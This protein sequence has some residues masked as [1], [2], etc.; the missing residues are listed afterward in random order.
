MKKAFANAIF[1]TFVAIGVTWAIMWLFAQKVY[2]FVPAE[3]LLKSA[4]VSMLIA[5][6]TGLLLEAQK[7]QMLDTS[8][9]LQKSKRQLQEALDELKRNSQLDSLTS[10]LNRGSFLQRLQQVHQD[11]GEGALLMIDA[12]DFKSINDMFGHAAGDRALRI[13]A[14]I[15]AI[16]V[17]SS[18]F[19]GRLGGEEFAVFVNGGDREDAKLSAEKIRSEIEQAEF[20][21]TEYR[22]HP[23][24]VSIGGELLTSSNTLP[25]ALAKAD[26]R[27]YLAKNFGKNRCKIPDAEVPP[28]ASPATAAT[29]ATA[30]SV[31]LAATD[32]VVIKQS[33]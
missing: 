31:A 30:A 11:G 1:I 20:W 3:A 23:L 28:S 15:I 21:P 10:V 32:P 6:P 24:G 5:F 17:G 16:S 22:R 9:R 25:A 18:D 27:M 2:G 8:K 12:D 7:S 13:I 19:V 29:A 4:L 26:E 14:D 33:A